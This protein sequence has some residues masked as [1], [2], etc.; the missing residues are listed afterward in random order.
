M[1]VKILGCGPSTGVPTVGCN[2]SVCMS[3]NPKNKRMRT[4]AI[5][6]L[7]DTN[8]LIDTG[9]DFRNQMLQNGFVE[10][11]AV[12]Y[13]H[14]HQDHTHGIEDMRSTGKFR[15]TPINIYGTKSVMDILHNRFP[16]VFEKS[17]LYPT[18]CYL[19]PNVCGEFERVKIGDL[20][21]DF[22]DQIHGNIHSSGFIF[23]DK[24]AYCT[25]VNHF[26]ERSLQILKDKKLDVLII[27]CACLHDAYNHFNFE[28]VQKIAQEIDAKRVI[29]THMNHEIDFD[30]VSKKCP[31]NCVL[32]FD[33]MEIC[34]N[35]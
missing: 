3:K 7:N 1:K 9:P 31:E 28:K 22:I 14:H 4:S 30:E 34:C 12:L 21:V 19:I 33:G 10:F 27:V 35:V 5:V 24:I 32:G 25:D 18:N 20:T 15:K 17:P 13:T 23:N 6:S 11:D 29:F 2:C 26:P 16:H 8:I